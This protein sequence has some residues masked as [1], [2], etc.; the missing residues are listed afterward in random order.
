MTAPPGT[1]PLSAEEAHLVGLCL[2]MGA[3]LCR[4][5][6]ELLDFVCTHQDEFD[7]VKAAR[8]SMASALEK[9]IARHQA[10]LDAQP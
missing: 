10:D 7:Q 9:R 3:T 2:A 6:A 4:S 5:Q 8:P 1:W